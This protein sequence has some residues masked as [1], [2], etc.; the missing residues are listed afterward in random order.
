LCVAEGTKCRVLGVGRKHQRLGDMQSGA[1]TDI[2]AVINNCQEAIHDAEKMAGVGASQ[3]IMGIAG[4]LVKGATT[5]ISYI[6]REPDAKIDLAELKNIVHKVQWKA[7]DEVR[8]ELAYETGY[9]EIDVKLI[10]AAITN[11]R[12]DG[13]KVTNPLGFQGKD[14]TI[15]I[16]NAFA[17]LVHYGALQTIA[18]ELDMELI[19]ITSEP[20]AVARSLGYEDGGNFS[21]IFIDI[22]GGTSD[23]ALVRN[24]SI[25]GTRMFNLGGRTFTKRLSQ[26]LNIGFEEA[27]EIKLAYSNEKLEKQSHRIVREAMKSDCEVWLSGVALTMGEFDNI[28]VM[29]SRIL[30]CGGGAHLPE[31]KE[32]LDSRDWIQSLPFAAKPQISFMNPKMVSNV[33]D[34]T[35]QL[36][37]LEDITPMALAN[38]ALEYLSEEQLLSKLLKKVVRLMQI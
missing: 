4:E 29:P 10:N 31:I 19:A 8:A 7:F 14:V 28:D 26:A 11:V 30:L 33:L 37:D 16:F 23:I 27:E 12:I 17:P 32:A 15:S 25:E 24:G 6:R 38:I 18:A 5:T 35:K 2:A 21:A 34:E 9:N 22:G 13:Y 1:V 20:Y 36:K 3:L